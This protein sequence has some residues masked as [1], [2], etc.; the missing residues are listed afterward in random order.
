MKKT[1]RISL[2]AA[3]M[4]LAMAMTAMAGQ[5]QESD[6]GTSYI[7]D[8]GTKAVGWNWIDNGDGTESCYCF[9][10][11][12]YLYKQ[13]GDAICKTPDGYEVNKKG[14][15][16]FDYNTL[17]KDTTRVPA[18]ESYPDDFSGV[19]EYDRKGNYGDYHFTITISYDPETQKL[20]ENVEQIP[21]I[22]TEECKPFTEDNIYSYI[23]YDYI[24]EYDDLRGVY[25]FKEDIDPDEGFGSMFFL[26]PGYMLHFEDNPDDFFDFDSWKWVAT[27]RN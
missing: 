13:T 6:A 5:W 15:W 16:M 4:C 26:E 18:A 9:D 25:Y 20:Y 10:E 27:P 24:N 3:L 2:A 21:Y 1:L 11:N 23:G 12:G 22:E 8:D 7:K 17:V 14:Q 19:Y